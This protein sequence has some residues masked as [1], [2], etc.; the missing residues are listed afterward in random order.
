MSASD[1]G[2]W[3][4]KAQQDTRSARR[5]L[6]DPPELEDA[7]FHVHQAVDKAAK[8]ILVAEGIRYPRGRGAGHDLDALTALI[9]S[10]SPL[11]VQA[12]QLAGLTPWAT[13]FRYPA[14][15]PHTAEPM[16]SKEDLERH[17]D[18]AEAFV[19]AVARHV[20]EVS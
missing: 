3:V 9:P 2:A 12:R 13:A 8:A 14:E 15:D 4:R 11:L 10:T 1:P 20:S 17:L 7:A 19:E 5:L 6:L 16:P 18:T